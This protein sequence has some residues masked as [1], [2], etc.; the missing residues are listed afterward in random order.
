MSPPSTVYAAKCLILSL[1]SIRLSS[2]SMPG[3]SG[4]FGCADRKN[5]RPIQRRTHNHC[6]LNIEN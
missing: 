5:N 6:I 3:I 2:A 4:S 1:Q